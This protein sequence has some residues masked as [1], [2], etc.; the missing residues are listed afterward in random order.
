[1]IENKK[2]NKLKILAITFLVLTLFV[3]FA[4]AAAN[5]SVTDCNTSNVNTYGSTK[6][7][8]SAPSSTIVNC[9][10]VSPVHNSGEYLGVVS[11]THSPTRPAK[12]VNVTFTVNGMRGTT[13]YLDSNNAIVLDTFSMNYDG[14]I[15]SGNMK[16]Y[17]T[18][19]GSKTPVFSVTTFNGVKS[20][21][22][23]Q[24]FVTGMEITDCEVNNVNVY[25]RNGQYDI[26]DKT[27]TGCTTSD[28]THTSNEYINF[29]NLVVTPIAGDTEQEF[30]F[31]T[32]TV[33]GAVIREV[34]HAIVQGYEI[35]YDINSDDGVMVD[36]NL[37]KAKYNNY[38]S[39]LAKLT[40]YSGAQSAYK[41]ANVYVGLINGITMNGAHQTYTPEIR[42]FDS[43]DVAVQTWE[44]PSLT[45]HWYATQ[46][47]EN[48]LSWSDKYFNNPTS[49]S[50]KYTADEIAGNYVIKVV[51]SDGTYTQ[52]SYADGYNLKIDV[53]KPKIEDSDKLAQVAFIIAGLV[54]LCLIGIL[55]FNLISGNADS[56]MI[57]ASLCIIGAVFIVLVVMIGLI[58]SISGIFSGIL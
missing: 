6:Y 7:D 40:A 44:V 42:Y 18:S 11:I 2:N 50:T 39:K 8:I 55:V 54:L 13:T 19:F 10:A 35:D 45:Y 22:A 43:V 20:F 28:I 37:F 1:M 57:I 4:S 12:N 56:K 16:A 31:S 17:Y 49:S 53:H 9:Q 3:G 5:V 25:G 29:G 23:E 33:K 38:G 21:N 32:G 48:A 41:Q 24:V 52:D 30:V 46:T 47:P 36:N 26:S 14:G 51:V 58:G 15:E 34:N 27:S